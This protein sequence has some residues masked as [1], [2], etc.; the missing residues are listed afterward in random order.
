MIKA[1]Y[2]RSVVRAPKGSWLRNGSSSVCCP[3]GR[4]PEAQCQKCVRIHADREAEVSGQGPYFGQCGWFTHFHG[5][6]VGSAIDRYAN[7]IKRVV[8]ILDKQLGQSKNGCLVAAK[9]SYADLSF[10]PCTLHPEHPRHLLF[11]FRCLRADHADTCRE[12]EHSILAWRPSRIGI[13]RSPSLRAVA[14]GPDLASCCGQG[15][16]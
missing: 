13:C 2:C 16:E 4:T 8:S 3:K 6:K 7:E 5:E 12:R 15:I 14:P 9:I 1:A 11:S 10:I